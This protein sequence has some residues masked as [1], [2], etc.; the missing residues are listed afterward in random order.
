MEDCRVTPPIVPQFDFM[1]EN[2]GENLSKG[3]HLLR[4]KRRRQVIWCMAH[5]EIDDTITVREV[6]K[7]IAAAEQRAHV[8]AVT[9][10]EYR[11]VYTNLVQN[12][13]PELEKAGAVQYNSDR[14]SISPGPNTEVLAAMAAVVVPLTQY[15]L[16]DNLY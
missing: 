4:A 8:N 12:H 16:K 2:L 7:Q 11:T 10:D 13:L 5:L 15:L 6:A 14:K 3:F 1:D 9:N